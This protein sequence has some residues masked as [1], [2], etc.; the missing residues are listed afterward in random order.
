MRGPAASEVDNGTKTE[1]ALTCYSRAL[2]AVQVVMGFERCGEAA[3]S[4]KDARAMS[5]LSFRG[6]CA[7]SFQLS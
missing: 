3:Y 2:G 6:G 5:P 1:C 4:P 7:L